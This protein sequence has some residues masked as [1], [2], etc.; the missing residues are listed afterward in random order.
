M[1]HMVT[2]GTC[3]VVSLLNH[4]LASSGIICCLVCSHLWY[5]VNDMRK[6]K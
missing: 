5:E 3:V 6:E 1:V 4:L 2:V